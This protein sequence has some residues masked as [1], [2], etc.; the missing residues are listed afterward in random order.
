MDVLMMRTQLYR[1]I[2]LK[3][4]IQAGAENQA[5]SPGLSSYRPSLGCGAPEPYIIHHYALDGSAPLLADDFYQH[6][7][8]LSVASALHQPTAGT[9]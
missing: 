5:L 9:V 1:A 4:E 8:A 2:Q 6:D 3:T 7:G